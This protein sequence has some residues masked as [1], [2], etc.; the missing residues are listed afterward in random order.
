MD[1]A[2]QASRSSFAE[3]HIAEAS[4]RRR[5]QLVAVALFA[6]VVACLPLFV[7]DVYT[8]NV[9]ILTLMYLA[10]STGWNILG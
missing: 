2:L 5:R 7:T 1:R 6:L 4:A 9:V 3:R 8:L 10:L